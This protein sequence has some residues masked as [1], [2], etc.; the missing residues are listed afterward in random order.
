MWEWPGNFLS[1]SGLMAFPH[2]NSQCVFLL[3]VPWNFCKHLQIS[4]PG[5]NC[6][7]ARAK[8]EIQTVNL[9]RWTLFQCKA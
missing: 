3:F 4:Q 6:Q 9:E 2:L 7:R 5:L 8:L 1:I